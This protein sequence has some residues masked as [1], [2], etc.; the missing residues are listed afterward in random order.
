MGNM[1]PGIVLPD[2]SIRSLYKVASLNSFIKNFT[3]LRDIR[4]YPY[5]NLQL[6]QVNTILGVTPLF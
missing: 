4:V 3:F 2:A 6:I 1:Y 5:A